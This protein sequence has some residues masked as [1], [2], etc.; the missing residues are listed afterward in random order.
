MKGSLLLRPKKV[1]RPYLTWHC[2]GITEA[3]YVA[4]I[5]YVL[6]AVQVWSKTVSNEGHFT[7]EEEPLFRPYL[8][9]HCSGMSEI[10]HVA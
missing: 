5:A 3:P 4:L 6:E 10:S 2:I 1:L 8:P 7:H 9:S